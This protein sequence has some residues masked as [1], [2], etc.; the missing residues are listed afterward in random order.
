MSI[1]KRI[2]LEELKSYLWNAAVLLQT[3][4]DA[5]SCK[6]YIFPLLMFKRISDVYDEEC[7]SVIEGYA[8]KEDLD[9]PGNHSFTIPKGSHWRDVREIK[10]KVGVAIVNAFRAIEQANPEKLSGIF[11]DGGWTNINRLPDEQ[12]KDLLDHFSTLTLSLNN[13]PEDELGQGYEYLIRKFADGGNIM[14]EINLIAKIKKIKF[15][16][17]IP[18]RA[19][20]Y[21]IEE[22][23]NK[24]GVRA[25]ISDDKSGFK[26][27]DDQLK[28]FF[29]LPGK[30]RPP[31]GEIVLGINKLGQP[32]FIKESGI[33]SKS[34]D[35]GRWDLKKKYLIEDIIIYITKY[36][37]N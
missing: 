32:V 19:I 34:F 20:N 13:C 21:A 24:T 7:S 31:L 10:E 17:I 29:Y 25:E 5:G 35:V 16:D 6:Q 9:F 4:I 11:G 12:L 28:L 26:V 1:S 33:F 23:E 8:E 22:F 30:N 27:K 3:H 15:L 18:E 14:S 2:T 37:I 36:M